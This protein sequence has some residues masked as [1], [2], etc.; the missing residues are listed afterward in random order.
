[1]AEVAVAERAYDEA[2]GLAADALRQVRGRR[3]DVVAEGL[4]TL[5]L[6]AAARGR[7]ARAARLFGAAEALREV[8]GAAR[9][10]SDRD[11]QELGNPGLFARLVATSEPHPEAV[12][13]ATAWA[14]GRSLPLELAI[15]DALAEGT[16][17]GSTT[18]GP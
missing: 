11:V 6:V 9:P 5:G 17:L 15:D 12:L 16:S 18:A 7:P 14:E 8:I 3:G 2:A 4:E 13:V 10:L 1:M